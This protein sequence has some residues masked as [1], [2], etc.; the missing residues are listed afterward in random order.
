MLGDFFGALPPIMAAHTPVPNKGSRESFSVP[1]TAHSPAPEQNY[2]LPRGVEA[3]PLIPADKESAQLPSAVSGDS[4]TPAEATRTPP[5]S[6]NAEKVN[7]SRL[8]VVKPAAPNSAPWIPRTMGL[9]LARKVPRL[10][11]VP[12]DKNPSHFGN[13]ELTG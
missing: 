8:I 3:Q 1:S 2:D 12:P 10:T 4:H 13:L 11:A 9:I 7:M 5:R 6:V